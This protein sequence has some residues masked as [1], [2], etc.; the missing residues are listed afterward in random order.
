MNKHRYRRVTRWKVIT[1]YTGK[2]VEVRLNTLTAKKWDVKDISVS[3][4]GRFTIVA[5]RVVRERV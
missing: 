4:Y 2:Q 3:T 5:K 1:A